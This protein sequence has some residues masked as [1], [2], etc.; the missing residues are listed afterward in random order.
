MVSYKKACTI[1]KYKY[2]HDFRV[3]L[4]VPACVMCVK[5][6]ITKT[7]RKSL[8]SVSRVQFL[9]AKNRYYTI[10]KFK[11]SKIELKFEYAR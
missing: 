8:S 9:F 1:Y 5:I 6:F 10:I 7:L 3:F 4:F 11:M 2:I